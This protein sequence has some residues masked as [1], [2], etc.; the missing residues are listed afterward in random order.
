LGH[1]GR[2]LIVLLVFGWC[3]FAVAKPQNA[4]AGWNDSTIDYHYNNFTDLRWKNAPEFCSDPSVKD[5]AP[6]K[7]F[8][9]SNDPFLTKFSKISIPE[10]P[11]VPYAMG[12][13]ASRGYWVIVDMH[14]WEEEINTYS[15]EEAMA[16]WESLGLKPPQL[17]SAG[18]ENLPFTQTEVSRQEQWINRAIYQGGPMMLMVSLFA[19]P[20]MMLLARWGKM[21][22]AKYREEGLKKHL[23]WSI[24]CWALNGVIMLSSGL[25][26]SQWFLF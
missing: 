19:L 22:F 9:L 18:D 2:I 26:L 8:Y 11:D 24:A 21:L 20:M 10:N 25:F 5:D 16:R 23:Y 3:L 12:R 4:M 17:V 7:C 6:E 14:W 13:E 1:I 15:Q